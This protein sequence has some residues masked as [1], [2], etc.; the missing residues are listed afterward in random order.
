MSLLDM[1]RM[2]SKI[3]TDNRFR[4]E[5]IADPERVCGVYDLEASEVKS[6][7][8]LDMSVVVKYAMMLQESRVSLAL[9]ALPVT[10]LLLGHDVHAISELYAQ[11]C[12]PVPASSSPMFNEARMFHQYLINL[13]DAGEL[14]TK[15]VREVSTYEMTLFFLASDVS[16]SETARTFARD[17]DGVADAGLGGEALKLKALKG[18]HARLVTFR[19]NIVELMPLIANGESPNVPEQATHMLFYKIPHEVG[20]KTNRVNGPTKDLLDL[21][22]GTRPVKSLLSELSGRYGVKTEAARAKLEAG[23][24]AALKHLLQT[25]VVTLRP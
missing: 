6:L 3:L 11:D 5:F 10:K 16:C 17:N 19:Y 20:V 12:P 24:F 23:C 4:S 25:S 8:S 9:E 1:Q 21:C 15:Y 7:V 2:F 14:K 22:D 18:E 13:V